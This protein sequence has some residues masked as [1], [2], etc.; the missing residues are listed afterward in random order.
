MANYQIFKDET[1]NT[2]TRFVVFSAGSSRFEFA[3]LHADQFADKTM[4][5][6]LESK[7]LGLVDHQTL[8]EP[9]RLEHIFQM[10]EIDAE[11]LRACLHDLI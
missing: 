6:D 8:D 10:N 9:G 4:L 2:T 5:L 11:Q 1:E 7:R 3:F